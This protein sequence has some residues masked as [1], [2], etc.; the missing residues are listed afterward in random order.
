MENFINNT[1]LGAEAGEIIK[2]KIYTIRGERVMLDFDLAEIYGYT[3]KAF[4]QQVRNNLAKFEGEDF[5]FRLTREEVTDLLRCKN[6]TSSWESCLRSQNVTLNEGNILRSQ[7]VTSSEKDSSRSNFLTLK[8]GRGSNVKYLPYAFTESGIYMLMTVL[9]GELATK[10]SRALIRTFR[11]MKDYIIENQSRLSEKGNLELAMETLNNSKDI[12][13]IKNEIQ[14]IDRKMARISNKVEN[15]VMRSEISPV[16]LDF[17]QRKE[18]NEFLFLNGELAKASETYIDIYAKAKK[19]IFIIDNYID[20][21]TLRHLQKI[22]RNVNVTIFSDNVGKCLCARD[23]LDFQKEF[24]EIKINFLRN[25]NKI[26]D[27][28]IVLDFGDANERVF[29]CGASAKDAGGRLTAINEF[30]GDVVKK[31]LNGVLERMLLNSKLELK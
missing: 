14:K 2:N 19:N 25:E 6:C 7:I 28:F 13:A 8:N 22:K 18:Q 1:E 20:I 30:D 23:Y 3:T 15:A 31:S 24:P 27:R 16:I 10:Q 21:K 9:R 11:M 17:S 12:G 26:H 4:N 5:M 29:H